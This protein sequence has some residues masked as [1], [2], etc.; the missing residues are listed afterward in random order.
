MKFVFIILIKFF[1]MTIKIKNDYIL[2]KNMI[3]YKK[4]KKYEL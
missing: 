2:I 1:K 4:L 3:F